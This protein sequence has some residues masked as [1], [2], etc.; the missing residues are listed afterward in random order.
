MSGLI[1]SALAAALALSAAGAPPAPR[2]R[3]AAT[4]GGELALRVDGVPRQDAVELRP[5][6]RLD[7]T[8]DLS[9]AVRAYGELLVAGLAARRDGRAESALLVRANE[10]W[11]EW[12][13]ARADLRAGYGAVPWGRLDE[14]QPTDV[15]NPIDTSRFLL[16]GRAMAR[17]PV[18]FVRG[19][20]FGPS[21]LVVEGVV[22]PWFRRSTFDELDEDTSPFNL[23]LGRSG[24]AEAAASPVPTAAVPLE[25]REP[26]GGWSSLS[27]G[28][29]ASV[30]VGRADVSVS[31]YR[32]FDAF[33][34]I[35]FEPASPVG[36]TVPGRFVERHERFTMVGADLEAVAGEWVVRG[37]VAAL[38]EKQLAGVTRAGL[39]DGRVIEAG[40]GVERRVGELRAYGMV[41]VRREWSPEDPAIANTDTSLVG[42]LERPF[43]RERYVARVFAL[44]NPGDRSGF[45]RAL[46]R[47]DAR[48]NVAVDVSGALFLGDGD[49]LVSRF[50]DRDFLFLRVGYYF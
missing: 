23:L 30:T 26:D 17:L 39:V 42:S 46:L 6:L 27:G 31:A 40:G 25:R 36:L 10:A 41:L 34:P 28:A 21:G 9:P 15:I 14:L 37:E 4:V 32:G 45:V 12:A 8:V 29:R 38:V 49:D 22:V 11:I 20:V 48:D 47:W 44:A 24:S 1:A 3:V 13:G 43:A 50:S 2:Q 16:D 19:R 7:A 33:G 5:E 35:V 18:G